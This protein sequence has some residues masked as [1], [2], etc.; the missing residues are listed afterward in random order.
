MHASRNISFSPKT[1]TFWKHIYQGCSFYAGKNPGIPSISL[2]CRKSVIKQILKIFVWYCI[3]KKDS[4]LYWQSKQVLC[5]RVFLLYYLLLLRSAC[6][7]VEGS[8][9][10][11]FCHTVCYFFFSPLLLCLQGGR[12]KA[13]FGRNCFPLKTL[14]SLLHARQCYGI[15]SK[16]D[17]LR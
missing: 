9:I 16:P 14:C 17:F 15:L 4:M 6:I 2:F 5:R 3:W 1:K 13:N 10:T 12:A 11:F 7:P 8:V